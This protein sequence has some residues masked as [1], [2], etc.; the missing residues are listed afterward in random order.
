M[1]ANLLRRFSDERS[2]GSLMHFP[3]DVESCKS[4]S[5]V[6]R[7]QSSHFGAGPVFR[8]VSGSGRNLGRVPIR[9]KGLCQLCAGRAEVA[10]PI[11]SGKK[12]YKKSKFTF[13]LVA[14]LRIEWF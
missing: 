2:F 5:A 14:A 11:G 3:R 7:A 4:I 1:D 10:E 8:E 6:R 13:V 9:P 12:N